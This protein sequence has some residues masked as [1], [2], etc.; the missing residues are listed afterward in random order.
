MAAS[1]KVIVFVAII[2]FKRVINKGRVLL[3]KEICALNSH[4]D[5]HYSWC[6]SDE[7]W[8][9]FT[10]FTCP[11][12][13]LAIHTLWQ[14]WTRGLTAL[15]FIRFDSSLTLACGVPYYVCMERSLNQAC[16]QANAGNGKEDC[17]MTSL[18][19]TQ[20]E[21]IGKKY[22]FC[23]NKPAWGP[24]VNI[25]ALLRWKCSENKLNEIETEPGS[26]FF[27]QYGSHH[28]V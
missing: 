2:R 3:G 4:D 26:C 22:L 1:V 6:L 8:G 11:V 16:K 23:F 14:Q 24:R 19:D 25:Y 18:Q 9:L 10:P 27:S 13:L 20:K 15:S 28:G 7:G 21:R 12:Q 17:Y 5:L